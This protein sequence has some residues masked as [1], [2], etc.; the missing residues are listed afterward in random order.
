MDCQR[1]YNLS[2]PTQKIDSQTS[3]FAVHKGAAEFNPCYLVCDGLPSGVYH[4]GGKRKD[5]KV[6]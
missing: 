6:N 3:R 1:L 5:I 2:T 4:T